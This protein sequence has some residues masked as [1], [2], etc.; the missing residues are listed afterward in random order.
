M[1]VFP[2]LNLLVKPFLK[3]FMF[4]IWPC[5]IHQNSVLVLKQYLE[6]CEFTDFIFTFGY[7][8]YPV[9][10]EFPLFV[11]DSEFQISSDG[12]HNTITAI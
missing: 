12:L 8:V 1:N 3:L 2:E 9:F 11:L 5:V 6:M 10:L 7:Q 4:T